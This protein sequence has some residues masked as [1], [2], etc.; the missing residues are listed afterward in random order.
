MRRF[1]ALACVAMFLGSSLAGCADPGAPAVDENQI[2][3][4]PQE[5]IEEQ[6]ERA[7]KKMNEMGG[8]D[9]YKTPG[10]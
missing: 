7:M 4:V 10:N 2:P 3:V 5:T 9:R 6:Q 1:F 8:G